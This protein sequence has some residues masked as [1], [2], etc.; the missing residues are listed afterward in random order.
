MALD[1][2]ADLGARNV[3]ITQE[4]S[5]FGLLR[6]ERSVR[7][8]RAA[9]G[10][11]DPVASVGAGDV[12]LAGFLAA[13]FNGLSLDDALR[14]GVGCAAASVLELGPGRF[15]LREATRLAATVQLDE[16]QPI[17]A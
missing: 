11:L 15:D 7:R 8:C 2:I 3:L 14:Q 13:R 9:I 4:T 5:C 16:L 10:R 17:T 6:E 12:L 1:A